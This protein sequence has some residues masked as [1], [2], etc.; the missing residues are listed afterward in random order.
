MAKRIFLTTVL[1]CLLAIFSSCSGRATSPVDSGNS[2]EPIVSF[3]NLAEGGGGSPLSLIAFARKMGEYPYENRELFVMPPSGAWDYRLTDNEYDD[4][5]PAFGPGGHALAFVS[6][7]GSGPW[8]N[9]D[10]YKFTPWGGITQ[11]TDDAW[12]FDASAT[13]WGPGF[14]T[15]ARLNTLIGAPF[16][17]VHVL[18]TDPWGAWRVFVNTGFIASYDPV[19][20][21]DG[22]TMCFAARPSGPG[23]FGS[24]ELYLLHK[25][26]AAPVQLTYFGDDP[27]NPVY[28]RNPGFDFTG[29]R[30]VFQTTLWGDTEIA[31]ITL[32]DEVPPEGYKP[33]RVTYNEA[34]DVEPCWSPSNL[35]I[36]FAT[37]RDGN[38]ELYKI[39][40]FNNPYGMPPPSPGIERLT[41]TPQDESNPDWSGY[42]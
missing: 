41:Y 22:Q 15:C 2:P 28:S 10:V 42:Y 37:N 12:E 5:Y 19:I 23:Y 30:I 26:D 11:L 33:T 21:P 17:V 36:C 3:R 1:I 35:W 39:F 31:Y 9:H 24:L 20:S 18:A 16:D 27:D 7:L 8:S 14:I 34:D 25:G 4:D 13:D 6:N 38:Y 29:K 32:Q 40:D